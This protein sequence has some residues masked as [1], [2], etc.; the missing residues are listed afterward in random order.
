MGAHPDSAL[1]SRF[2][3]ETLVIKPSPSQTLK[4]LFSAASTSAAA[5][6]ESATS[7][8]SLIAKSTRRY[9]RRLSATQAAKAARQ[10]QG[11]AAVP[12]PASHVPTS[13]SSESRD[14]LDTDSY[15]LVAVRSPSTV[16][17]DYKN[18]RRGSFAAAAANNHSRHSSSRSRSRT[19]PSLRG[20]TSSSGSGNLGPL[21]AADRV[22][23]AARDVLD[24]LTSGR[25][26]LARQK[27]R[28]ASTRRQSGSG[29]A[30]LRGDNPLDSQSSVS[31]CADGLASVEAASDDLPLRRERSSRDPRIRQ[32][33]ADSVS[34]S[35]ST[36]ASS[37][38][39]WDGSSSSNDAIPHR[40][41][42]PELA[43]TRPRP[44]H[45]PAN[46]RPLAPP[47]PSIPP[48]QARPR[49][50]SVGN[51]TSFSAH[52]VRIPSRDKVIGLSRGHRELF[53]RL[54][55][56]GQTSYTTTVATL[57]DAQDRSGKLGEFV[58]AL[59]ADSS[60]AAAVSVAE[61]PRPSDSVSAQSFPSETGPAAPSEHLAPIEL[62]P[63]L[64]HSPFPFS[65][66]ASG[67]D[68]HEASS[69]DDPTSALDSFVATDTGATA[70]TGK[71]LFLAL[72]SVF[73]I[74]SP[75][76]P[77]VASGQQGQHP[78]LVATPTSPSG[79][80]HKSI[81]PDVGDS[82]PYYAEGEEKEEP[83]AA[84]LCYVP[85]LPLRPPPNSHRSSSTS[86]DSDPLCSPPS[87]EADSLLGVAFCE[88]GTEKYFEVM[89]DQLHRFDHV[90]DR[91]CGAA[92]SAVHV[93]NSLTY[94]Q[95][96]ETVE[97][98]AGSRF[99][100]AAFGFTRPRL[101]SRASST[102]GGVDPAYPPDA[103]STAASQHNSPLQCCDP[104]RQRL[105]WSRHSTSDRTIEIFIDRTDFSL[106]LLETGNHAALP[107]SPG[108]PT[109]YA[110]LLAFLRT[111]MFP[112]FLS[113]PQLDAS[114]FSP[115]T[116]ATE[117]DSK[118]GLVAVLRQNPAVVLTYLGAFET[119]KDE[120]RWLGLRAAERAC[121][122]YIRR[123]RRIGF[124]EQ[125][126]T[127]DRD[128]AIARIAQRRFVRREGWI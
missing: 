11:E 95:S 69:L 40:G 112:P 51:Q 24:K 15:V 34:T 63:P 44:K 35:L 54:N 104:A 27:S 7:A 55:V 64:P 110:A 41:R 62:P 47:S 5:A 91:Q 4:S 53:V 93:R 82:R 71:K 84:D 81:H 2:S 45:L 16:D 61:E 115:H 94:G 56:G 30:P 3:A 38:S 21:A 67:I 102:C 88:T 108:T 122:D 25:A 39:G 60:S 119:I 19:R 8:T 9:H 92:E 125:G 46:P 68:N 1:R 65:V 52:A 74:P 98:G 48:L 97:D 29:S 13:S 113:I 106:P 73:D 75:T 22:A 76:T 114:T 36:T 70:H 12:P 49:T 118:V 116:S 28:S 20:R 121:D 78:L 18:G 50:R 66:E 80:K 99:D 123:L 96:P 85:I 90:Q 105:S 59:L 10:E 26:P 14:G 72:P 57:L 31:T 111:G 6:A 42:L 77:K 37:K 124:G 127:R 120:A 87:S 32:V 58:E 79:F 33:T 89:R 23:G 107:H 117:A 128:A 86:S 17:D 43:A 83:A 103:R 101:G 126:S 100:H 109:V